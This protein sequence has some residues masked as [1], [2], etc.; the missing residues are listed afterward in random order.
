[1]EKEILE[2]GYITHALTDENDEVYGVIKE[3]YYNF[4][5]YKANHKFYWSEVY[6]EPSYFVQIIRKG[7]LLVDATPEELAMYFEQSKVNLH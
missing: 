3:S 4:A 7:T 6:C 5:I 1:M 2:R